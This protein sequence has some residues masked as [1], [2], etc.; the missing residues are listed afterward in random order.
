VRGGFILGSGNDR[1]S[2]RA[3]TNDTA[4]IISRKRMLEVLMT[5]KRLDRIIR[6]LFRA[7]SCN[8]PGEFIAVEF[9]LGSLE[10]HAHKFQA[11]WP[12]ATES[13]HG[14][15]QALLGVIGDSEH[16]P[17]QIVLSGPEMQEW[18]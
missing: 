17:R 14:E 12:C 11:V 4:G 9:T 16:A 13:L 7:E 18:L 10:K 5:R 6:K 15:R 2:H 1:P 8:P 3:G